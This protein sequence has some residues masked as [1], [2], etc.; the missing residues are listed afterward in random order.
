M[1]QETSI[2]EMPNLADVVEVTLPNLSEKL[3]KSEE[4]RQRKEWRQEHRIEILIASALGCVKKE[5]LRAAKEGITQCRIVDSRCFQ[6]DRVTE[7]DMDEV[8]IALLRHLR[9]FD[10]KTFWVAGSMYV[11]CGLHVEVS[12]DSQVRKRLR[13]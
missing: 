7:A 13:G 3:R 1:L 9:G 5:M 8:Q 6:F 12:W 10:V 2:P 4:E 11:T